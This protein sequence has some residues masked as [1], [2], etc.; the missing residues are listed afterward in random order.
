MT[1]E[2]EPM[3]TLVVLIT[4]AFVLA[5]PA[6]ASKNDDSVLKL[7]VN[8]SH[9][10]SD[11]QF[12]KVWDTMHPTYQKIVGRSFWQSC[13][14]AQANKTSAMGVEFDASSVHVTDSFTDTITLPV[15][16][17]VNVTAVTL[18]AKFK[19]LGA[20]HSVTDT[21]N[22]TKVG[23]KWKGLWTPA[24]FKAYKNHKCPA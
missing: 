3:K 15:L 16:G 19:Y 8:L 18:A 14:V 17:R 9:W 20:T 22:Y 11:G 21:V 6:T 1:T 23:G 4:A 10:N 7:A 2:G 5:A 24:Q 13:K 12:G